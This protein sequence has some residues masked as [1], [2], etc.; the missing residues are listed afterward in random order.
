MATCT[1]YKLKFI[2]IY[3]VPNVHEGN[4][5]I[6]VGKGWY[7]FIFRGELKWS[8]T[9]QKLYQG[10]SNMCFTNQVDNVHQVMFFAKCDRW[11]YVSSFAQHFV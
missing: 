7:E 1:L 5:Q 9:T 6:M 2:F 4:T 10:H 3:T 8:T 11:Q